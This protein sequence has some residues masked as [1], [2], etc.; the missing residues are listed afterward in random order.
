MAGIALGVG[1]A[2]VAGGAY[3]SSQG[4]KKGAAGQA[5]Q[6]EAQAQTA[7]AAADKVSAA[8][9]AQQA[10]VEA[11]GAE[12]D[13]RIGAASQ[14]QQTFAEDRQYLYNRVGQTKYFDAEGN[15][16]SGGQVGQYGSIDTSMGTFSPEQLTAGMQIQ[17]D[18][19][20]NS[21]GKSTTQN[22]VILPDGT[23]YDV[24]KGRGKK[25]ETPGTINV[26]GLLSDEDKHNVELQTRL[27]TPAGQR[28][29]MLSA[30]STGLLKGAMGI[31]D[32][33]HAR[34]VEPGVTATKEQSASWYRMAQ[35][36]WRDMGAAKGG[37]VAQAMRQ[38]VGE[39]E[40]L[41]QATAMAID[42]VR[43]VLQNVQVFS[44]NFAQQQEMWEQL[45][46][47]GEGQGVLSKSFTDISLALDTFWSAN[48]APMLI[49]G[50][51]T[52]MGAQIQAAGIEGQIQTTAGQQEFLSAAQW[53][54][55]GGALT[56]VGGTLATAGAGGLTA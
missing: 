36:A 22:Y 15:F 52:N 49:A 14:Q 21:K 39:M 38:T 12:S 37:S 56:K 16:N 45:W 8:G 20:T 25:G 41:R 28:A 5:K 51:R 27:Y 7:Q 2:A 24:G 13:R 32:P 40:N 46:L 9:A 33:I 31:P 17:Q 6:I 10:Y 35:A 4:A 23:R 3:M 43:T 29:G 34:F 55:A 44:L 47:T 19:T 53:S 48:T 18:T 54:I 30:T 11:V 26:L 42:G 50:A 1:L